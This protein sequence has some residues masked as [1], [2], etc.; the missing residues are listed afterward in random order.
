MTGRAGLAAVLLGF[1]AL[2]GCVDV[3]TVLAATEAFSIRVPDLSFG[4]TWTV[5]YHSD[6]S[7][8]TYTVRVGEAPEVMLN[9]Y[10]QPTE[11]VGVTTAHARD[12]YG[13]GSSFRSNRISIELEGGNVLSAGDHAWGSSL[14]CAQGPTPL[15]PAPYY[16]ET[17][18]RQ[19]AFEDHP[20]PH[21]FLDLLGETIVDGKTVERRLVESGSGRLH[22]TQVTFVPF[23]KRMVETSAFGMPEQRETMLVERTID[24]AYQ[25][26]GAHQASGKYHLIELLYLADGLPV[27][28]KVLLSPKMA[29]ARYGIER[30]ELLSY[31]PGRSPVPFGTNPLPPSFAPHHPDAIPRPWGGSDPA[32][33]LAAP[34]PYSEAVTWI[35]NDPRTLQTRLWLDTHRDAYP[36]RADY[37]RDDANRT[38]RWEILFTDGKG[39]AAATVRRQ[40]SAL[41]AP[42]DSA[43]LAIGYSTNGRAPAP[44]QARSALVVNADQAL[45]AARQFMEPGDDWSLFSWQVDGRVLGHPS[46]TDSIRPVYGFGAVHRQVRES[47]LPGLD[48]EAVQY[49]PGPRID[50]STGALLPGPEFR[51]GCPNA[52][53][54]PWPLGMG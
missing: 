15:G 44:S 48:G 29:E 12:A 23:G 54:L 35:R 45:F 41:G 21:G 25:S 32:G 22:S 43:I 52:L 4:E 17:S 33:H 18:V 19:T 49:G 31:K 14:S 27:P 39:H 1:P 6:G 40:Y 50:A 26:E 8:A 30:Q 46:T 13:A 20:V 10:G 51:A 2:A 47:G 7:K 5:A 38:Y 28:L 24:V 9:R 16:N 36:L 37:T 3:G 34:F 53:G 11:V 42:V